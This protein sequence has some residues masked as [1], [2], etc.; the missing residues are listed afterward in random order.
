[1]HW[2]GSPP[3][4]QHYVKIT[5]P[6]GTSYEEVFDHQLPG[7]HDSS[8]T[9]A[10][11]FGHGWYVQQRSAI[12]LVPSFVARLERNVIINEQHAESGSI[13]VGPNSQCR[14]TSGYFDSRMSAGSSVFFAARFAG[15]KEGDEIRMTA[16]GVAEMFESPRTAWFVLTGSSAR[17]LR[18]EGVD[19]LA[20]RA[21]PC[22][23][24]PFM[25]AELGGRARPDGSG[26]G[27]AELL[28]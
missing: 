24:H 15:L 16:T 19:L 6:A 3:A 18:R 12:L 23:M 2:S 7:W 26:D 25:A 9:V 13:I 27:A 28:G 1:M 10:R 8:R 5:I 21:L 20:G 17:K 4:N 11:Q 14:G 22:S